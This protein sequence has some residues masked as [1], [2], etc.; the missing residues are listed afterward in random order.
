MS[1]QNSRKNQSQN[2]TQNTVPEHAGQDRAEHPDRGQSC[3]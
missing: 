3:K 1:K 2:Q